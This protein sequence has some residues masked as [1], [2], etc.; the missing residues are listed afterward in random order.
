[1]TQFNPTPEKRQGDYGSSADL[2]SLLGRSLLVVDDE[3]LIRHSLARDFAIAGLDV[4]TTANGEEAVALIAA[5]VFD[6][7]VTDLM[8]PGLDGLEVLAAAKRKSPTTIV[9][10]LT[11]NGVMESAINAL[12]LGAD[13]FLQ[14][15]CDSD[16]L[17]Y[18]ISACFVKQEMQRKI[19][20]YEEFL[21]VC[22]YCRKIRDD[23]R[24][25]KGG[26]RWYSLEEYFNRIGR[27]RISH[28]CCPD[29]FADQMKNLDSDRDKSPSA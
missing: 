15:P 14:K 21:P 7:V 13:D 22:C 10:I 4:T 6:I 20:L 5:A 24:G 28:G 27:V 25:K 19:A 17:L 3:A 9:V 16:E 29:C 1:M 23:R 26:G 8:M 18:R 2:S 11:G 12:R